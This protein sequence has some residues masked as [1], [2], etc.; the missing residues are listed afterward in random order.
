LCIWSFNFSSDQFFSAVAYAN[1]SENNQLKVT[2]YYSHF[3]MN[4]IIRQMILTVS[5]LRDVFL[6][7]VMINTSAYMVIVLYRHQRECKHLHSIRHLTASTEKKAT[8]TILLL[9]VFFVV[10]YWV[11]LIILPTS[12][13]LWRY[14]P[15]ILT[16]HKCVMNAYPTTSPLVQNSSDNKIINVLKNL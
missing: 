15:V 1:V 2:K 16:V 4:N 10:M 9:V 12:V 11:D 6:T 7:G 14:D 5:T 13:L 3:P 8:Q